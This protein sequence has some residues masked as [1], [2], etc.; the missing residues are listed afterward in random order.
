MQ[1]MH[2][3]ALQGRHWLADDHWDVCSTF[4]LVDE[5]VGIPF[6]LSVLFCAAVWF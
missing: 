6:G 4:I 5:L 2:I 3:N 1:H